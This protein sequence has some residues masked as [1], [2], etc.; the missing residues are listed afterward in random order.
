M[1]MG[2]RPYLACL[3]ALLASCAS[4]LH[5]P[6]QELVQLEPDESRVFGSI[7]VVVAPD[8]AEA[9]RERSGGLLSGLGSWLSADASDATFEVSFSRKGSSGRSLKLGPT[10]PKAYASLLEQGDYRIH[11]ACDAWLGDPIPLDSTFHVNGG[12]TL[13]LGR[14]RLLVPA[15]VGEPGTL[16]LFGAQITTCVSEDLAL[17]GE[18]YRA[19]LPAPMERLIR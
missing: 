17:L 14:L 6:A 2:V 19:V 12:E 4:A 5:M 8:D 3:F 1:P 11:V 15:R 9:P 7:E 16:P 10:A 18:E 13:Y